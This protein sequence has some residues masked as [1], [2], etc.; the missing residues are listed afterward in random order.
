MVHSY[1]NDVETSAL[2]DTGAQV[3]IISSEWLEHTLPE[4]NVQ[5]IENLLQEKNDLRAANGTTIPYVG[6]VVLNF[7]LVN[8]EDDRHL[9]VPFLA[10][11]EKLEPPIIGYNVTEE[12]VT[13][14]A[15]N[16]PTGADNRANIKCIISSFDN[17]NES[18][19]GA[20]VNFLS[21]SCFSEVCSIRS[22]K[23]DIVIPRGSTSYVPCLAN[24]GYIVRL[25]PLIFDPD[26]YAQ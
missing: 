10:T 24:T 18:K 25:T 11:K 20:L 14:T 12:I 16:P 8:S 2:R 3:S 19:A 22:G 9:T 17:V 7:E 15:A 21:S 1:L 23:R 6:W 5:P 4:E 13:G 26:E